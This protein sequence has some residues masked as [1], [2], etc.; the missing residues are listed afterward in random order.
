MGGSVDLN[1]GD[2]VGGSC[3]SFCFV[4]VCRDSEFAAAGSQWR[5]MNMFLFK[6][7]SRA[8]SD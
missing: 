1:E 7:V 8:S 3:F 6:Y 2:Q 4:S 5:D